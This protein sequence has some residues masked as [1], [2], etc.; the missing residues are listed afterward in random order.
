MEKLGDAKKKQF[1][2]AFSTEQML[3]EQICLYHQKDI[4]QGEI[5]WLWACNQLV[6]KYLKESESAFQIFLS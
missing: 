5:C 2:I 4:W 1:E 6:A 3:M